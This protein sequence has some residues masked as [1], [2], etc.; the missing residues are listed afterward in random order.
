MAPLSTTSGARSANGP[1]M[2]ILAVFMALMMAVPI[3]PFIAGDAG[4]DHASHMA[5]GTGASADDGYGWSVTYIGDVNED[6]DDDV[7]VGAPYHDGGGTD[8]GSVFIFFGPRT[9]LNTTDADITIYGAA[10]DDRLGWD[11]AADDVNFD[12]E[13]DLIMG[14]PGGDKVYVLWHTIL[15]SAGV[16]DLATPPGGTV[17]LTGT[18]SSDF[19]ASVSGAGNFDGTNG[20]EVIVGAPNASSADGKAF[21]YNGAGGMSSA[22]V[23]LTLNMTGGALGLLGFAVSGAG[24]F[25]GTGLS[26][27]EIAV[28]APGNASLGTPNSGVVYVVAGGTSGTV[29]CD[30][31]GN[32]LRIEDQLGDTGIGSS[33]AP[34]YDMTGDGMQDLA[35]G[36]PNGTGQVF[37]VPGTNNLG[38]RITTMSMPTLTGNTNMHFGHSVATAG[39]VNFD[40]DPDVI[41]GAPWHGN[42]SK[43]SVF[44][45]FGNG[46]WSSSTS[47]VYTQADIIKVGPSPRSQF[48]KDVG[49]NGDYDSDGKDDFIVGS[50][51]TPKVAGLGIREGSAHLYRHNVVPTLS[52]GGK[53]LVTPIS[54]TFNGSADFTFEI[55]YTDPENDKPQWVKME[56][57]S[58]ADGSKTSAYPGNSQFPAMT[59]TG[60]GNDYTGGMEYQLTTTLPHGQ[61]YYKFIGRASTG[62]ITEVKYPLTGDLPL[63]PFVDSIAPRVTYLNATSTGD[64]LDGD[65]EPDSEGPFGENGTC[66]ITWLAP[67]DDKDLG[68]LGE[69]GTYDIKY[70]EDEIT[71]A[72][73]DQTA[74]V[75]E[76]GVDIPVVGPANTQ[77]FLI[78]T[79][80]VPGNWYWFAIRTTDGHNNTSPMSDGYSRDPS[81]QAFKI[82]KDHT[83]PID[84]GVWGV[85][86]YDTPADHGG[87][88]T[89]SWR[90]G[91]STDYADITHYNVYISLSPITNDL[92]QPMKPVIK[93]HPHTD[94]TMATIETLEGGQPLQDGTLYYV[95]VTALDEWK[96]QAKVIIPEL[97]TGG[98][99]SPMDNFDDPPAVLTGLTA[100]DTPDDYGRSISVGW[101]PCNE[102]DFDFYFLYVSIQPIKDLGDPILEK[103][104]P[105]DD[106]Y[107]V[108]EYQG[109]SLKDGNNYYF[110]VTAVDWNE[111][112]NT[113]IVKGSNYVGPV[114]PRNNTDEDPPATVEGVKAFDKPN[115]SGGN[116]TLQWNATEARDFDMYRIYMSTSPI[117][118]LFGMEPAFVHP[119]KGTTPVE[120]VIGT[121]DGERLTDGLG[122]HFTV[123]VVDYNGDEGNEDKTITEGNTFGPAESVDNTDF[124]PPVRLEG[125]TINDFGKTWVELKWN[126]L[127]RETMP[128]FNQYIVIFARERSVV[129][130]SDTTWEGQNDV[131]LTFIETSTTR[132]YGLLKGREYHFRMVAM[133]DNFNVNYTAASKDIFETLLGGNQ[134][135]VLS[136]PPSPHLNIDPAAGDTD[137]KFTFRIQW[138]D[139][140]GDTYEEKGFLKVVVDNV[141]L[142]A[143][144]IL[145][146]GDGLRGAVYKLEYTRPFTAG[147]HRVHFLANDRPDTL[148]PVRFPAGNET[149]TFTV[150]GEDVSTGSTTTDDEGDTVQIIVM[151]AIM[152][153][154]FGG[155][156]G[157][158]YVADQK[159]QKK[160]RK[161][162][163]EEEKKRKEYADH[164]KKVGEWGC[165]CGKTKAP[166]DEEAIC[167]ECGDVHEILEMDQDLLAVTKEAG[168]GTA[169]ATVDQ[170]PEDPLAKAGLARDFGAVAPPLGGPPPAPGGPLPPAGMAPPGG[171]AAPGGPA[172]PGGPAAPGA[173]PAPPGPAP[174]GSQMLPPA[175][176]APPPSPPAP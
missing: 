32:V 56:L 165:A 128:D 14:A 92:L 156:G 106:K 22:S 43:G 95:A 161:K 103:F 118:D 7:A 148:N 134:P 164:I 89:V 70:S 152:L 75:T 105:E 141:T 113:D 143:K 21:V 133:D 57:Y 131:N 69:N 61:Y 116:L 19:G 124:E 167:V 111:K 150:E 142:Q 38:R 132:V 17:T 159:R 34:V 58:K 107:E 26:S 93:H 99:A 115:D 60:A 146:K 24:D 72:N 129:P 5:W 169:G 48:G 44:V 78:I 29:T 63:G 175:G 4:G 135:P 62:N 86:L 1:D 66:N 40:G 147:T 67:G 144:F 120:M 94:G 173:A 36:A 176:G 51:F 9:S 153:A 112:E 20:A 82:V 171:P 172:V 12:G 55:I 35:V 30:T 117:T 41:V 73:W 45:F 33:L 109:T 52:A 139:P 64:D 81:A 100:Y 71:A 87:S 28:G 16:I 80:L 122:Y 127:N 42:L 2:M 54:G 168:I 126:P 37:I 166:M 149:L 79:G 68:D 138:K 96:N 102:P 50:P 98:P 114:V 49:G 154:V 84:T 174:P 160:E 145:E 15:F 110:V 31:D 77:E 90:R 65:G 88:L 8:T 23:Y 25:D 13:Q 136:A 163:R 137:T 18:A 46:G 85:E 170:V 39:D 101:D 74:S 3:M 155:V 27:V 162:R 151:I 76:L 11:I 104:T 83:P 53:N 47:L 121:F 6:G 140:D 108:D 59:K 10:T 123:T 119:T 125:V 91:L 97:N 158:M 157:G 130:E